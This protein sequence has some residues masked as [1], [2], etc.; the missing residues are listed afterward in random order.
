MSA[1]IK[2]GVHCTRAKEASS[3]AANRLTA[4]VLASPGAPSI[5]TCPP[6][7]KAMSNRSTSAL[8]PTRPA[9]MPAL[10]APTR[11]L[12]PRRLWGEGLIGMDCMVFIDLRLIV[13]DRNGGSLGYEAMHVK[14]RRGV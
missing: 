8:Q 10:G 1:G 5:R 12:N 2:S 9:S 13:A 7:S 11:S 4:L 6:L 3:P 14:F